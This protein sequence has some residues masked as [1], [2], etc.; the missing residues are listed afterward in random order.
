M[1]THFSWLGLI[2]DILGCLGLYAWIRYDVRKFRQRQRHYYGNDQ[3]APAKAKSEEKSS[4]GEKI[5]VGCAFTFMGVI[6]LLF[7]YLI[8]NA[9]AISVGSISRHLTTITV[10]TQALQ[11]LP[12]SP[13]S[14]V[15][16]AATC[17]DLYLIQPRDSSLPVTFEFV[18]PIFYYDR[19][20]DGF[21]LFV[22]E[23]RQDAVL[24]TFEDRYICPSDLSPLFFCTD[25]L[26]RTH[27]KVHIPLGSLQVCSID[28][29][30]ATSVPPTH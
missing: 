1:F 18:Q 7:C 6:F 30:Q 23:T 17:Q 5:I 4:R 24:V 13:S 14:Q 20:R 11:P 16:F 12:I 8:G 19:H 2:F 3:P 9:V 21:Y 25:S 22:Q 10:K 26:S 28:S 27:Y 15:Y 29:L